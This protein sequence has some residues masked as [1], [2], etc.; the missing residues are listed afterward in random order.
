MEHDDSYAEEHHYEPETHPTHQEAEEPQE[1]DPANNQQQ[2]KNHKQQ[3]QSKSPPPPSQPAQNQY[4][5]PKYPPQSP[6]HYPPQASPQNFPP[7]ANYQH[8]SPQQ[9]YFHGQP[10]QPHPQTYQPQQQAYATQPRSPYNP[11]PAPPQPMHGNGGYGATA[12]G[13]QNGAAAP[14]YMVQQPPFQP[15]YGKKEGTVGWTT[16]LFDCMD[17]PTNAL[18]TACCPCYTFGQVAEIVDNGHTTCAT[19]GIL[20]GCIAFFIGI[21]CLISCSYRSKLRNQYDLIEVPA[22]DWLTHCFCEWCALCQEYRELK[23][24]GLDPSIGKS[25]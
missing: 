23:N 6:S 1:A 9:G 25:S 7:Q 12:Q 22:A 11:G 2:Q 21:P 17:D 5:N 24:R 16:G 15:A 3:Y 4:A 10:M 13:V 18:I 20:Y 8:H 19:S 14:G